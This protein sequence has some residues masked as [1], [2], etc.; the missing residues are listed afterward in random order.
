MESD[1]IR[2]RRGT[3][4]EFVYRDPD[5]GISAQVD[6][7]LLFLGSNFSELRRAYASAMRIF[8]SSGKRSE[9]IKRLAD[10]HEIQ[11][12]YEIGESNGKV[13]LTMREA[14]L[15]TPGPLDD[16]EFAA[17]FTHRR[18]ARL[19]PLGLD[20]FA[21]LGELMPLLEGGRSE[22]EIEQMLASRLSAD[23]CA[24]ASGLLEWFKQEGLVQADAVAGREGKWL[25]FVGPRITTLGHS[26]LLMQSGRTTVLIDPIVTLKMGSPKSALE[27]FRIRP[28]AICCTHNHWDHCNPET[29]IRFDKSIP[30]L[31]PKVMR[32][33]AFNPAILPMLERLGFNDIREVALWEP[34]IV[35]DIEIVP[36]PFYG[37]AD[38]P[39][40]EID[41]FTYVVRTE[42]LTVYG[43]VDSYRDQWGDMAAVMERVEREYHP[44]VAF[45][46]VSRV[47]Y[48]YRNGGQNEFCAYINEDLVGASFQ[49]TAGPEEAA[50]WSRS[51]GARLLVPYATFEFTRWADYPQVMRFGAAL[52]EIGAGDR[53]FP[54]RPLDSIS[55]ADLKRTVRS[56]ARRGVFMS[57]H[58]GI[59]SVQRL[60]RLSGLSLAGRAIVRTLRGGRHYLAKARAAAHN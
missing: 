2:L 1:A 26:T 14:T 52:K 46:P 38:E 48:T 60:A 50:Q 29:L 21:A 43:G 17:R 19:Y 23:D 5:E 31:I 30:V 22:A 4:I 18:D 56:R 15:H 59:S 44:D 20:R 58:R 10:S 16:V 9:L 27:I 32:P 36:V 41:H 51:L 47:V 45:L 35:G 40:A 11:R 49:Y 54:L 33:S 13:S 57:W 3:S 24:W 34:L 25:E 12:H 28:D 42:G 8:E 37:E 6:C 55:T 7:R 39:G 53:F